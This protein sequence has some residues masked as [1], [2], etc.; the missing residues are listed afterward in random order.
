MRFN[1]TLWLIIIVTINMVHGAFGG[2]YFLIN[3]FYDWKSYLHNSNIFPVLFIYLGQ[4]KQFKEVIHR[5]TVQK[6]NKNISVITVTSYKGNYT[7]GFF[8]PW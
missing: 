6:V 4:D 8:F 1:I 7:E 2:W 5:L 3:I